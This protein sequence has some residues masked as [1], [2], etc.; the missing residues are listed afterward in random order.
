MIAYR[1]T[2]VHKDEY[3]QAILLN[4]LLRNYIEHKDFDL[5]N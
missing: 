2:C 5:A 4:S 3:G 1:T